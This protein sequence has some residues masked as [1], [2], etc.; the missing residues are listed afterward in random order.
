MGLL[1]QSVGKNALSV[2][3]MSEN[4][5]MGVTKQRMDVSSWGS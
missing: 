2:T 3:E 1:A 5:S 4:R